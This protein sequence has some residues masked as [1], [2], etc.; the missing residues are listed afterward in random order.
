[1]APLG[2]LIADLR[3]Q[4]PFGMYVSG[5]IISGK[6]SLIFNLINNAE[7]HFYP[8]PQRIVYDHAVWQDR[9]LSVKNVEF[10][11]DLESVL[12]NDYFDKSVNNL[13]VLDDVM[14]DISRNKKAADLFTRGIHHNNISVVFISQNLYKQGPSMRDIVLNCQYLIL[15]ENTRDVTQLLHLRRQL[16]IKH[17]VEAYGKAIKEPYGHLMVDLKPRTDHRL[18]LQSNIS[19]RRVIYVQK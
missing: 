18:K 1:M 6:S 10:T 5:P 7:L 2:V 8:V 9:F 17:L 19:G 4:C 3:F 14:S 12:Q 13:L 15:F 11:T 16:G